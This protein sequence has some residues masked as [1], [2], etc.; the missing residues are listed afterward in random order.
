MHL[1]SPRVIPPRIIFIPR[2]TVGACLLQQGQALS[3]LAALHKT[4]IPFF[5]FCFFTGTQL[6]FLAHTQLFF[7]EIN[8]S[9]LCITV[10]SFLRHGRFGHRGLSAGRFFSRFPCLTLSSQLLTG[11]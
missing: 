3:F 10:Y 9:P 2:Y 6:L 11:Q 4:P 5:F 1:L 7:L 8:T